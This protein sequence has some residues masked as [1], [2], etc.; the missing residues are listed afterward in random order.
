MGNEGVDEDIV[1]D[2]DDDGTVGD[3]SGGLEDDR[4]GDRCQICDT[5]NGSLVISNLTKMLKMRFLTKVTESPAK[6]ERLKRR[7]IGAV[8]GCMGRYII[9]S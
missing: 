5:V 6:C 9:G 8:E 7:L 1:D 3:V 2:G 4:R